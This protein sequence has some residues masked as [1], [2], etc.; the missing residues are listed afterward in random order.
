MV[1]LPAYV[2]P[3]K[4]ISLFL[5]FTNNAKYQKLDNTE[6]PASKS[7][8]DYYILPLH[9]YT[10]L[11]A[12]LSIQ[13]LISLWFFGGAKVTMDSASN[14]G[15]ML[16]DEELD[17]LADDSVNSPNNSTSNGISTLR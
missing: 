4:G 15:W 17:K 5:L 3:T 2:M 13:H 12:Q 7:T 8:S 10:L 1:S 16:T 9:T 6:P 14:N 11:Q